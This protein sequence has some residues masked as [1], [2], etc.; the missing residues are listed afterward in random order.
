MAAGF[1]KGQVYLPECFQGI[2]IWKEHLK[3]CSKD[4]YLPPVS[5]DI[6][7]SNL[8][9]ALIMCPV[10]NTPG[11]QQ[12]VPYLNPLDGK[13][14]NRIY[15][16]DADGTISEKMVYVVFNE[17]IRLSE[18]HMDLHGGDAV[19]DHEQCVLYDTGVSTKE[20]DEKE[21]EMARYF[22]P[23]IIRV[24]ENGWPNTSSTEVA[25]LGI[26][27]LTT[28]AGALGAYREDDI[29]YHYRGIINV[30]KWLKMLPGPPEEPKD[31]KIVASTVSVKVKHGGV[32][33]PY[34]QIGDTFKQ[35]DLMAEVKDIF[36][37]VIEQIHAPISGIASMMYPKRVKIAGDPIYSIFGF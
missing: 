37:N 10:L 2:C 11:F 14:M 36:G 21:A 5:V 15:P 6:D 7:P 20:V 13:N 8:K 31:I 27:S 34:V 28:E 3:A 25:K 18:W 4:Y 26:P 19:E 29:Q 35:G 9:G 1:E 33:Y 32:F 22:L 30:M 17:L 24:F 16:G 23:G 12:G